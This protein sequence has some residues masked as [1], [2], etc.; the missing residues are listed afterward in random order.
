MLPSYFNTCNFTSFTRQL[1]IYGFSKLKTAEGVTFRHPLFRRDG[2]HL[3]ERITR[4]PCKTLKQDE[5]ARSNIDGHQDYKAL[6]KQAL[7]YQCNMR[8]LEAEMEK[9]R[10][11]NARLRARKN[12]QQE[13]VTDERVSNLLSVIEALVGEEG[14]E[15]G[16]QIKH[17]FQNYKQRMEQQDR[18]SVKNIIDNNFINSQNFDTT[19]LSSISSAADANRASGECSQ[20]DGRT[21][22]KSTEESYGELDGC[23]QNCAAQHVCQDATALHLDADSI[24]LMGLT[25]DT[26]IAD[27]EAPW[28]AY[29]NARTSQYFE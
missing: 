16:T 13:T 9:M 5:D 22:I 18:Y 19:L 23:A 21:E 10:E 17:A 20:L 1:N 26:E 7:S 11:E 3:L 14:N 28:L 4:S 2:E 6:N 15:Q 12:A 29:D 8:V 25:F 24:S 27:G